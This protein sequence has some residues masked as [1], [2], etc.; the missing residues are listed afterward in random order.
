MGANLLM[1]VIL[2]VVFVALVLWV[3]VRL[4]APRRREEQADVERE[5]RARP[6]AQRPDSEPQRA[7]VE[8]VPEPGP[9]ASGASLQPERPG[10]E[11]PTP[12]P[13]IDADIV[14]AAE[15]ERSEPAEPP[16]TA[17][18][19][20][21]IEPVEPVA[22]PEP[23]ESPASLNPPESPDAP[24]P[25]KPA[26][27][28]RIEIPP[29]PK[30]VESAAPPAPEAAAVKAKPKP[31][32]KRA[33][34]K[35]KKKTADDPRQAQ[36]LGVPAIVH[37]AYRNIRTWTTSLTPGR[38]LPSILTDPKVERG[39]PTTY[40]FN[41]KQKPYSIVKTDLTEHD[42]GGVG[43]LVHERIRLLDGKGGKLFEM[44]LVTADIGSDETPGE[45]TALTQGPWLDD[46]RELNT[47][48]SKDSKRIGT[49]FRKKFRAKEQVRL[50]RDFGV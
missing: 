41:L 38:A 48:S 18:P 7:M 20:E 43:P 17:A 25:R 32:R 40:R 44:S 3:A 5:P 27:A 33:A 6:A 36:N 16:V 12:V 45:V 42:S 8:P 35:K 49:D 9:P 13:E 1:T 4:R 24:E 19:P 31:K 15:P 11:A 39:D 46:F 22:S 21:P 10:V 37:D 23:A 14:A 2:G 47:L 30:P 34:R 28:E 50:K 29:E 26:I